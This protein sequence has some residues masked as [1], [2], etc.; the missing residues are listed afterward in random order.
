MDPVDS[1]PSA[2]P[3]AVLEEVP[4]FVRPFDGTPDVGGFFD[5]GSAVDHRQLTRNGT[6]AYGRRGHSGYDF[7]MRIG[8]PVRAMAAGRVVEAGEQG[9]IKCGGKVVD[10]SV[11]VRI[12]HDPAPDGERYTT[13]LL[14]L[15]DVTVAKGDVVSAGQVVGHSGNT[16]C[17]SG[18]HL[19]VTVLRARGLAHDP[20]IDPY[21]WA[22]RGADPHEEP[23]VWL[24]K[25]GEAPALRRHARRPREERHTFGP[26]RIQG[27]DAL[28]PVGGEWLDLRNPGPEPRRIG[29]LVV[30][31]DAGDRLVLPDRTIPPGE[32]LRIW[33]RRP[34]G[35]RGVSWG[36]ERE[37]WNDLGDC[38][39]LLDSDGALIASL[40]FGPKSVFCPG[41]P[42]P[43][44]EDDV[45]AT[46]TDEGVPLA[47]PAVP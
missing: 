39:R 38:A 1:S 12:A 29:G 19:H 32:L 45:E 11:I 20:A 33:T 36:L 42:A 18:P 17:S 35:A 46:E 6:L 24:W 27:T 30:A 31:N 8:T 21:G 10:S 47:V 4:F 25:P 34:D 40:R 3:A 41:A 5:H 9:P 22:G 13:L 23:A 44:P 43:D 7:S 26:A 16:G 28:D 37:A 14:H 15:S 2:R